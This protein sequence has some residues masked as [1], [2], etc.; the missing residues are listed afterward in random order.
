MYL[1]MERERE[2]D[3]SYTSRKPECPEENLPKTAGSTPTLPLMGHRFSGWRYLSSKQQDRHAGRVPGDGAVVPLG[4]SAEN[5]QQ[6]VHQALVENCR[7]VPTPDQLGHVI[8]GYE[9]RIMHR[10]RPILHEV[11]DNAEEP[12]VA[13]DAPQGELDY[14]LRTGV[15]KLPL[16]VMGP[17]WSI[18]LHHNVSATLF[19]GRPSMMVIP[20][21]RWTR[22]PWH[23]FSFSEEERDRAAPGRAS[24]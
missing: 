17:G 11:T 22:P 5:S 7:S 21:A 4:I 23:R 18:S 16:R 9:R 8:I 24:S 19:R 15:L 3:V 6:R 10:H 12:I 20:A 14:R 2:R 1:A 13:Q